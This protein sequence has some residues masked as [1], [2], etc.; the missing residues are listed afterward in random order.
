MTVT[1][2]GGVPMSRPRVMLVVAC[3]A[4]LWC[5][6]SLAVLGS[7]HAGAGTWHPA[8]EVLATGALNISGSAEVYS[9]SCASAGHCAV[10]GTYQDGS[11]N[12]QAFVA[13][14]T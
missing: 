13:S 6:A 10:G 4:A 14:Q 12:T 3:A 8:I 5:A 11:G 9:V 1:S 7:A 2:H